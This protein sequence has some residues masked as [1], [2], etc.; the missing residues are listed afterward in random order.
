MNVQGDL[1]KAQNLS[2]EPDNLNHT[3]LA[4]ST[5]R[6]P[7][8]WPWAAILALITGVSGKDKRGI[9]LRRKRAG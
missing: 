6:M 5:A 2:N 7:G 8:T 9:E 3:R 4:G 1:V